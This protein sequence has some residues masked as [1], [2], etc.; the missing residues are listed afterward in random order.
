MIEGRIRCFHPVAV[1]SPEVH[2][3]K[4]TVSPRP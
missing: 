4:L 3:P 1:N 2:Q